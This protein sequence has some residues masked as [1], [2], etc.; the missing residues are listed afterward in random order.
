MPEIRVDY[1]TEEEILLLNR[2]TR[3][4]EKDCK[5]IVVKQLGRFGQSGAK[6]FVAYFNEASKSLPLAVKIHS[7]HYIKRE[8]KAISEARN[9]FPDAF[10]SYKPVYKENLGALAYRLISQQ[11]E[12]G[13]FKVQDLKSRIEDNCGVDEIEQ[14]LDSLYKNG[15]KNAH[16]AAKSQKVLLKNEY[17]WYLR[18]NAA[19]LR[20]QTMLGK[21]RSEKIEFLGATIYH[22][23]VALR[24]LLEKQLTVHCGP[25]HGDLHPSNVV[26]DQDQN[27]KLIDFAWSHR[28]HVL[29]DFVLME[30]SVRFFMLPKY[31]NFNRQLAFD[32]ALLNETF[33]IPP[34]SANKDSLE[35]TYHRTARII[36]KIRAHARNVCGT[37]Y[38]FRDYL[39]VQFL[40]LYGLL[41]VDGYPMHVSLLALG[42]IAN[43]LKQTGYI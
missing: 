14:L 25:V 39:A 10:S 42:L 43:R 5:I 24:S 37:K 12:P 27:S 6:V 40:L 3:I 19:K 4:I 30:N 32:C 1:F 13:Q 15:C 23:L 29:K 17:K 7:K 16:N 28:G 21:A 34:M 11:N 41:K 31:V 18:K 20:I 35:I 8:A 33:P 26:L 9:Y 2:Y 38:D 36:G 22:P